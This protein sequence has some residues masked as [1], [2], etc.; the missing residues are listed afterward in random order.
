LTVN[1]PW[2]ELVQTCMETPDIDQ[3]VEI[4]QHI[5]RLLPVESRIKLPTYITND[6][7]NKT[8]DFLEERLNSQHSL[9]SRKT[10][11]MNYTLLDYAKPNQ[12]SHPLQ[13]D[14]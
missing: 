10:T 14:F 9:K 6:Y 7:I 5:N 11:K 1:T 4:L 8:L 13:L 12:S 3:R 2:L